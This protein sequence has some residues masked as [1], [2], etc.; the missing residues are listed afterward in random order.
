MVGI[1][2]YPRQP[3][4][5]CVQ[6]AKEMGAALSMPEYAFDVSMLLNE[7][8]TRRCLKEKPEAFFRSQA[9]TYLFYFSGTAG[10][11]M[12]ESS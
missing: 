2:S 3:L 1:N 6:D 5:V 11:P 7:Q 10:L 8:V 12:L 9:E 4:N